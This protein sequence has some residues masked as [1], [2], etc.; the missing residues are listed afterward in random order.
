M[1]GRESDGSVAKPA[2]RVT[3]LIV[4]RPVP[5]GGDIDGG[6]MRRPGR[7]PDVERLPVS[8]VVEI[9]AVL[10]VAL[11]AI[12]LRRRPAGHRR[13][14]PARQVEHEDL[15]AVLAADR[16]EIS[17][18]QIQ[19]ARVAD[20]LV[21]D[22]RAVGSDA[23]V[24]IVTRN[25]Q[26]EEPVVPPRPRVQTHHVPVDSAAV[27]PCEVTAHEQVILVAG[28]RLYLSVGRMQESAPHSARR[29]IDLGDVVSSHPADTLEFA[30]DIRG[31]AVT[32]GE[33]D[34]IDRAVDVRVPTRY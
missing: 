24:H 9:A 13:P 32:V 31:G 15:L 16:G 7:G 17:L 12:E 19:L 1:G 2:Q 33:V 3:P 21:V 34:G 25:P 11:A 27:D 23:W 5:G 30:A 28:H 4:P 22:P 20:L 18:D 14:R 29:R 26:M 8:A 6:V 10:R